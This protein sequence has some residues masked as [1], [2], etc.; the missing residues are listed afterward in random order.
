MTN[1]ELMSLF[2]R[3]KTRTSPSMKQALRAV[4]V[5]GNTW[6]EASIRYSVTESGILRAMRRLGLRAA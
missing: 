2:N 5:R 1:D 3:S 6:R 4:L